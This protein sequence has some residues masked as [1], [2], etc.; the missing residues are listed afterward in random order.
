MARL[1]A[2]TVECAPK[3]LDSADIV[4]E[5]ISQHLRAPG[6]L[7]GQPTLSKRKLADLQSPVSCLR[8][9]YVG[10]G[11][12][13]PAISYWKFSTNIML[14]CGSRFASRK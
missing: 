13:Q 7:Y 3:R 14:L 12:I 4:R 2:W 11:V 8:D 9:G 10:W 5:A 1:T 6:H